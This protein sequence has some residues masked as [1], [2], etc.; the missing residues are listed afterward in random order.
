MPILITR[1][2]QI[3]RSV[4]VVA[5]TCT[6]PRTR[7]RQLKCPAWGQACSNCGKP[8]PLSRECRAKKVPQVVRKGPEAN[9][10]AMDTPI[11]HITFNQMAGTYTAK[12]TSQIM[13]IEAYVVLFSPKPDPRQAGDIPRNCS[14]NMAIFPD[15]GA[16]IRL[17]GLKHLQNMGLST[18]NLIP[19]RKVVRTVGGFTFMYQGWLPVE[20]NV[21]D[22]TTKQA[23]YICKKSKGCI[24]AKQPALT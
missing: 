9:E 13:E 20:L 12:D 11:T 21:Q 6:V 15:S 22:K 17:R 16:T 1:L 14:T 10:A 8:N 5:A 3:T 24:S 4:G 7:S 2:N 23:L 19:S 18:N